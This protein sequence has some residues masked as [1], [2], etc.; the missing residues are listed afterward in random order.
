MRKQL[1]TK[2]LLIAASLFMGTSAWG[3]VTTTLLEYGTND[4]PWTAER[5]CS[6]LILVDSFACYS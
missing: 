4:V 5:L 1:L 6:V 2:M 3:Q